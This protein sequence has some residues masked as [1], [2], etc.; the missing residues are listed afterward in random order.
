MT[1]KDTIS[2]KDLD[3]DQESAV[4]GISEKTMYNSIQTS[5]PKD[6]LIN[7]DA[8]SRPVLSKSTIIFLAIQ[9]C[10]VV[11]GD[12][13]TSP[14]YTFSSVFMDTPTREDILGA[15]SII[16]W[17]LTLVVIVK[18]TV[19]VLSADDNGEGGTFALYSLLSRYANISWNNPNAVNRAGFNRYPTGDIKGINRNFRRYIENSNFLRHLINFL[20]IIGVCMVLADGMLTP[21]QTVI[22]AIQGLRIKAPSITDASRTGISEVILILIFVIQP[23]GT[24]K[25]GMAFAPIVIIWLAMNFAFGIYNV[26]HYDASAFQ[27]FSP[28]W[29]YDWFNR[30]GSQGWQMMGGTLLCLTGVEALYADLGHFSTPSIRISSICFVYP[31]LLMAYIGQAA[32]MMTDTTGLAWT[33]AYYAAVPPA[34]FWFAFIMAVLAAIVASQALISGSFSI[35]HQAMNLSCFPQLEVVHTSNRF[36]GQIYIP[37]AN[38]ILMIGT[39][40]IAGGF[41]N[42]VALGN[43]YGACVITT[44]FITTI[45]ITI[46]S[47]L[48]WRWNIIFSLIFLIFFGIIDGAYFTSTMRKV[49]DGAWFTIATAVVLSSVMGIWRYGSLRTWD[50]ENKLKIQLRRDKLENNQD[51]TMEKLPDTAKTES[52]MVVFDPAGFDIPSVYQHMQNVLKIQPTVAIFCHLRRV[53]SATVQPHERMIVFRGDSY[54]TYR[55]IL[56]QGYKELPD[57]EQELGIKL[58]DHILTLVDEDEAIA[59]RRARDSQISYLTN[60]NNVNAKPNSFILKRLG[61]EIYAWLKRNTLENQQAIFGVPVDKTVQVGMQYDL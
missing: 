16:I 6:I 39:V 15:L 23:F 37:V 4:D 13:G 11:Y 27:A 7:T 46:L 40:A 52:L 2:N 9:S 55:V 61:I 60:T 50:F 34:A 45:L 53:N 49:P 29:I 20:S 59:I 19:I 1:D 18:Y 35:L 25:I 5:N 30:H 36:R 47:L 57:N 44:T 14:L 17:S 22:G 32:Y 42:T 12:L 48:V 33:N 43:A 28:Y 26:V 3:I 56:R 31:C 54:L 24:T 51:G 58:C 41:Q 10:G 38:W 8:P 21:A